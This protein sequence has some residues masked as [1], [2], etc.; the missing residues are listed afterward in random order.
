MPPPHL[1]VLNIQEHDD[2]P[3]RT[4]GGWLRWTTPAP[5]AAVPKLTARLGFSRAA[6]LKAA[7]GGEVAAVETA[8]PAIAQDEAA[9][10]ANAQPEP[11][12]S[13]I[14]QAEPAPSLPTEAPRVEAA[15]AEAAPAEAVAAEAVR[16]EPAAPRVILAPPPLI[17][18]A[19]RPPEED[20]LAGL[21]PAQVPLRIRIDAVPVAAPPAPL[22]AVALREPRPPAAQRAFKIG[23]AGSK[24]RHAM[25]AIEVSAWLQGAMEA[26]RGRDPILGR[27]RLWW[28]LLFSAVMI[29][30]MAYAA[31]WLGLAATGSEFLSTRLGQEAWMLLGGAEAA[32]VYWALL[33][34]IAMVSLM[35]RP[36][37]PVLILLA[38]TWWVW[39]GLH[40]AWLAGWLAQRIPPLPLP[41]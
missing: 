12:Q 19:A 36:L 39:T 6:R 17:A 34:G 22:P 24:P 9:Q 7:G 41:G 20:L 8:R 25:S 10:P 35:L 38:G 15:P 13:V 21:P 11:A 37:E 3:A 31:G 23:R 14:A 16:A 4:K 5:T 33:F 27:P 18:R 2:K 1:A 32:W 30:P 28:W 29:G 26:G 40:A